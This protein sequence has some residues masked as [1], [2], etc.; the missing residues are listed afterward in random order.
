MAFATGTPLTRSPER[1]QL[2]FV[3]FWQET[4]VSSETWKHKQV[5]QYDGGTAHLLRR[6][7]P[8]QDKQT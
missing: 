8:L 3:L 5:V 2:I 7:R 6:Q 1:E 4:G